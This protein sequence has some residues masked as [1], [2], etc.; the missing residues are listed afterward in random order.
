MATLAQAFDENMFNWFF[1]VHDLMEIYQGDRIVRS[2]GKMLYK[3][4]QV[5]FTGRDHFTLFNEL[6]EI[7]YAMIPYLK[8]FFKN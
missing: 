2:N 6:H 4:Q 8:Y 3:F 7:C 5:N 1:G